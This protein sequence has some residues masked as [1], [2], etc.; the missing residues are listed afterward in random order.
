G[1]RA[2]AV[3][4]QPW[5]VGGALLVVLLGTLRPL[6]GAAGVAVDGSFFARFVAPFALAAAALVVVAGAVRPSLRR[7]GHLAHAGFLVLLAGVLGT[8]TGASASATLDPGDAVSVAGWTVRNEGVTVE[9]VRD[10][11]AVVAE[12]TL[13]RGDDE[14]ARLRPGRVAYPERGLL[15]A[16]TALRSSPLAD[17]QVVLHSADDT[18]RALVEVHVRPFLVWVWWGGLLLAASAA[19]AAVVAARAAQVTAPRAE[20][21]RATSS[22]SSSSSSVA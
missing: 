17:V 3:H 16:E 14:K 21:Q 8:T 1:R 22:S 13:L 2:R 18:G 12:L 19:W 7:P 10:R 20:V 6:A 9:R 4:A 15:L 11:D 5:L